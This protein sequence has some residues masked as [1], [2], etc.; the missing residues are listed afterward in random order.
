[1]KIKMLRVLPGA[2]AL[3][4]S[5]FIFS[6]GFAD[7]LVVGTTSGGNCIPFGCFATSEYQQ[8]YSNSAFSSAITITGLTFFDTFNPGG[9]FDSGTY[10]FFL[11]SG[12]STV[13]SL[14]SNLSSNIGA[15]NQLFFSGT[16]S[17]PTGAQFTI[18]GA[19]P[20]IYNPASGDLLLT[21]LSN[22]NST[23]VFGY[24]DSANT[25]QIERGLVDAFGTEVDNGFGLVTQFNYIAS[26]PEASTWAM[27]LLGFAGIGFVG[28]R[29]KSKLALLTAS[30]TNNFMTD[31]GSYA[32]VVAAAQ[33]TAVTPNTVGN[34]RYH[35]QMARE[36]GRKDCTVAHPVQIELGLRP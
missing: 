24:V 30:R 23:S 18:S 7:T 36:N 15:N 12:G 5:T 10:Q 6:S 29:R 27:M 19:P 11:S 9:S 33:A 14:N 16:L 32:S 22:S 21:I 2:M 13:G 26:V 35:E 20:F 31:G 3:A 34:S 1:M 8:V 28:Y 17:G 4:I 25:S